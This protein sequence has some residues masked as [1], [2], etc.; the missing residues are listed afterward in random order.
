MNLRIDQDRITRELQELAAISEAP[1]PVVT[2]IVF[3]EAG[4]RGRALVKRQCE[5]AGLQVRLDAA[6]VLRL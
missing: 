1:A 3:T 6:L 2:R 5:A 4:L